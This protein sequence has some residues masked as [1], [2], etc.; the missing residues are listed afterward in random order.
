MVSRAVDL[1]G[2]L[3][4]EELPRVLVC[5]VLALIEHMANRNPAL[6]SSLG[7]QVNLRAR[8]WWIWH[9][10]ACRTMNSNGS[11]LHSSARVRLVLASQL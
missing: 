5:L 3:D 8:I 9:A 4:V 10:F 6:R 7:L 1:L 2:L 11:D